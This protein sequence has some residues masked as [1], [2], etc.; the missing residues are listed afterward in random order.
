MSVPTPSFLNSED[1][2]LELARAHLL[3]AIDESTQGLSAIKRRISPIELARHHPA[4]AVGIA[5]VVGFFA[6]RKPRVVRIPETRPWRPWWKRGV[7]MCL[8]FLF[9]RL[10]ALGLQ[11]ISFAQTLQVFKK[12]G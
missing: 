4:A 1:E 3:A 11:R 6:A 12:A 8:N 7:G 10:L 9:R 5:V 2:A